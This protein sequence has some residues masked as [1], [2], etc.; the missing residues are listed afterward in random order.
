LGDMGELIGGGSHMGD[1]ARTSPLFA[2]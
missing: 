2:R 1:Q